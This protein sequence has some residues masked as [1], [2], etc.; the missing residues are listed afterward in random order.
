M[1]TE[2]DILHADDKNLENFGGTLSPEEAERL[3]SYLTVEYV[4]L[5]LV[6]N[7]F[8]DGDRATYLFNESIQN[9]FRAVIMENG[10]FAP[11]DATNNVTR[12]PS[13]VMRDMQV[14]SD[15]ASIGNRSQ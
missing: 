6:L 8:S 10:L 4:R 14:Q 9:M 13:R 1:P 3:F 7:F 15:Y 12:V 5:P 11:V 2:D